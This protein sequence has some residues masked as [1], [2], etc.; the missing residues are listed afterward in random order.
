MLLYYTSVLDK[1]GFDL[2]ALAL[3][4]L[5]L[6]LMVFNRWFNHNRATGTLLLLI[7]H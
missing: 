7:W 4:Q 2:I 3:W 6:R 1:N 5:W